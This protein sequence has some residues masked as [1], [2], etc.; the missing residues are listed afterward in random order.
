MITTVHMQDGFARLIPG[1][2]A[3][4]GPGMFMCNIGLGVVV[5]MGLNAMNVVGVVR[6]QM[7]KHRL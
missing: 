3:S 1:R 5:R 7:Q 2:C 6:N 4:V